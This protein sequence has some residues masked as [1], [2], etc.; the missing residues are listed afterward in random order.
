MQNKIKGA[1]NNFYLQLCK[2]QPL[3]KETNKFCNSCKQQNIGKN[4]TAEGDYT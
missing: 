2:L 1:A 3:K 4:T